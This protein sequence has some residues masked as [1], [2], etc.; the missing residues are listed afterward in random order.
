[1]G[2]ENFDVISFKDQEKRHHPL[3]EAETNRHEFTILAVQRSGIQAGMAKLRC[4]TVYIPVFSGNS[5]AEGKG[6][7]GQHA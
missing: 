3:P 7:C 5:Q 1:M 4:D 6:L 2:L